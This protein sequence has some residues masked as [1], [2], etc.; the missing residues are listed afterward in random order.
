MQLSRFNLNMIII[1]AVFV[2][3]GRFFNHGDAI[4]LSKDQRSLI[5]YAHQLVRKIK[6][7]SVVGKDGKFQVFILFT[8]RYCFIDFLFDVRKRI[9]IFNVLLPIIL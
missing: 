8:I 9:Y 4:K 6:E 5:I 1:D 7:N 2:W 3:F